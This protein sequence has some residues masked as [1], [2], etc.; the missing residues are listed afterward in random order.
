[1]GNSPRVNA[2]EVV[3][4]FSTGSP[5]IDRTRA[6]LA[7]PEAQAFF[8]AEGRVDEFQVMVEH[9]EE[10]ESYG[11]ALMAAGAR[12]RCCGA[13]RTVPAPSCGR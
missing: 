11:A 2:Y 10:I 1:M 12:R 6:Y 7:L 3:Y 5:D 9:P 4:V 13:G 8:N